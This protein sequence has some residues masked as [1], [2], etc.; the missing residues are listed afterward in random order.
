MSGIGCAARFPYYV[1]AYGMHSIHGRAAAIATGLA[2]SR[3]DLSVWVVSGDGDALSIGGNHLLHALRRNVNITILLFNNQV[4]G[5]TKGQYSPTSPLGQVTGPTPMGSIDWPLNPVSVALGAE[6]TFV[7]RAIDTDRAHL[8][9]VLHAATR[10][11]GAAFVEILQNC[12]VYNDGAFDHVRDAKE[13]R[14][15]LE[16]GAPMRF[17]AEREKGVRLGED[18]SAEIVD[19]AEVGEDALLVHDAHADSPAIAFALGRLG[20]PVPARSRS[21]SSATSSGRSTT[22]SWPRRSTTPGARRAKATSPPC[23]TRAT[24]GRSPDRAEFRSS[25]CVTTIPPP[26][27]A[28]HGLSSS[29]S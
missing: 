6:A 2:A 11:K 22:T 23:C 12:N 9:E 27:V 16:H 17:G 1:N 10:H 14:I 26:W 20:Y 8:T 4:Y 13:N 25:R 3:P 19:V 18:G 29:S 24:P 21:A 28:G 5:L 7:A 15:V